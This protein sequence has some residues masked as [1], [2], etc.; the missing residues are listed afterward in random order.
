[1]R[2]VLCDG[3]RVGLWIECVVLMFCVKIDVFLLW[4]V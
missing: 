1:M 3:S 2:G 4:V